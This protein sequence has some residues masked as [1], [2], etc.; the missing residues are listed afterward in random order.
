M[1]STAFISGIKKVTGKWCKQRKREE[2]ESSARTN[3]HYAMTCYRKMTIKDAAWQVI[4]KAYMKASNNGKLPAHARQI[5]YA[6]RGEI[7]ERTGRRL[8]GQYFCQT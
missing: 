8:D 7:Q 2:R 3:R 1:D 6:A 5:M 4:E